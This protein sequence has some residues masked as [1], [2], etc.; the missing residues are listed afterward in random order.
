MTT[1]DVNR[2][3]SYERDACRKLELEGVSTHSFRR[4]ALT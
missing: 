3:I 2:S 4:T 1:S